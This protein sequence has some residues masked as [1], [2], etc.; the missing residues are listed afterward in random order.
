VQQRLPPSIIPQSFIETNVST[1]KISRPHAGAVISFL[2]KSLLFSLLA[3]T[4]MEAPVYAAAGGPH[5]YWT[6]PAGTGAWN[7][8]QYI[9][10]SADQPMNFWSHEFYLQG[11]DTGYIGLQDTPNGKT[12][13]FS[14]WNATSGTAT[15]SGFN[16]QGGAE[17]GPVW[18]CMGNYNWKVGVRYRLRLWET[19]SAPNGVTWVGTV[20]DT[21][22]GVET[23][24][25]YLTSR[26]GQNLISYSVNWIESYSLNSVTNPDVVCN[27]KQPATGY[28]E[29][30]TAN[31]GAITF[32]PNYPS[33][34]ACGSHNSGENNAVFIYQ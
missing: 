13:I 32:K 22:T 6:N 9:T 21:S 27:S 1:V 31:N 11:G 29:Y 8:D 33:N 20:Q 12:A 23:A 7:L 4:A 5:Q 3:F 2:K 28:F 26:S 24:I 14:L 25:G 17:N 30:P 19:A 15:T 16:C 10:I 18:R 34:V